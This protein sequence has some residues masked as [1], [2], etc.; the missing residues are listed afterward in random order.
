MAANSPTIATTII[1]STKVK[2]GCAR[3]ETR[4]ES[5][6]IIGAGLMIDRLIR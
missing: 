6:D 3:F 1:I 4:A 2:A 5:E